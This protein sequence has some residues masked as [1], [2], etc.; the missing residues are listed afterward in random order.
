MSLLS[1]DNSKGI[2]STA[3]FAGKADT[4]S[5]ANYEWILDSGASDHMTCQ[6]KFLS[7]EK[8][9]LCDSNITIPDGSSITTNTCGDV[10]LNSSITCFTRTYVCMQSCF[11]Q[12]A[13]IIIEL[14]CSFFP[15]LLCS[16]GP[17]HEKA[18]WHG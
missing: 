3:N 8:R 13:N 15:F 4:F 1:L 5:A 17:S 16:A 2:D 11:Y 9:L 7:N 6:K 14:C 10:S 12:Q 18:D